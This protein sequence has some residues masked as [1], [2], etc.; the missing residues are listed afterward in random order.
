M[1]KLTLFICS[2]LQIQIHAQ[3]LNNFDELYRLAL[4]SNSEIQQFVLQNESLEYKRK[5]VSLFD[6]TE[7][8]AIIGQ[9]NSHLRDANYQISQSIS[10]PYKFIQ[11]GNVLKQKLFL[12]DMEKIQFERKLKLK[13]SQHW[14]KAIYWKHIEKL[15]LKEDSLIVEFVKIAKAKVKFGEAKTIEKSIAELEASMIQQDLLEIDGK[16][17]DEILALKLLLNQNIDIEPI[18]SSLI[19]ELPA[20]GSISDKHSNLNVAN[21]LLNLSKQELKY[22]RSSLLPDIRVGY[23]LQSIVGPQEIG[24]VVKYYDRQ[25]R[26]QSLHLG[27]SLPLFNWRSNSNMLRSNKVEIA[28]QMLGVEREKFALQQQLDNEIKHYQIQKQIYQNYISGSLVAA[29]EMTRKAKF[30]YQDGEIPY[31]EYLQSIQSSLELQKKYFQSIDELNQSILLIQYY[32][33]P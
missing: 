18:A 20:V 3:N 26:F 6:P 24:G 4:K 5:S 17:R 29:E 28:A 27:L 30:A 23:N 16:Y 15:T 25:P 22:S 11:K 13:L 10:N 1:R 14:Y 2:V 32:T 12:N 9:N 7:V 8:S 33:Q 31:I 21:A 19:L